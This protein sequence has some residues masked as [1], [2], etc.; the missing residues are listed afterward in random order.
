MLIFS[1]ICVGS[2]MESSL[3]STEVRVSLWSTLHSIAHCNSKYGGISFSRRGLSR[4]VPGSHVPL[5]EVL[6]L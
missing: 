3:S 2:I 5:G 4:F 1:E 6:V